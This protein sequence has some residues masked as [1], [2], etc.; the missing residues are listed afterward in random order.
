LGYFC[1]DERDHRPGERLVFNRTIPLKDSW[2][3]KGR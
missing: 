2:G 3:K 1:A